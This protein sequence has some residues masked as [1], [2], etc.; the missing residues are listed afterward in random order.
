MSERDAV[1]AAACARMA[2]AARYLRQIRG[3]TQTTKVAS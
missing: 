3:T 2:A 1:L